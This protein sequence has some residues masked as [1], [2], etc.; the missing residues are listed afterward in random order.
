MTG[1]LDLHALEQ[2]LAGSELSFHLRHFAQAGSTQ[3]LVLRAAAAGTPE[4]LTVFAEEQ[5]LGRGRSGRS[6][7][8]PA[9]SAL[10]FSLLLRPPG[11]PAGWGA[12]SLVAAVAV[13]EGVEGA[14]GPPVEIKW[15]NDCLS[16]GRKLAGIL[17]ES[18]AAPPSS[19]RLVLG[20][21]C[22]VAWGG[23]SLPEEVRAA[24]TAC[25]LEGHPVER[26]VLARELLL[27]LDRR[28]RE[29]RTAGFGA[30]R[31]AWLG[32]A[33]DLGREVLLQL[34]QRTISGRA[35]G[36]SLEG[37]L[38]LATASGEIR[39]GTGEVVVGP[40]PLP[41]SPEDL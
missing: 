41:P 3:D 16:R 15:P 21:G 22:N 26:T 36:V 5:L 28:Y 39:V 4:G 31:E 33:P 7:D 34:Q 14:G 10:L 11:P 2:G 38:I 32:R 29:W 24:G 27:S 20:V 17:S 23:M 30:A 35:L 37:E 9:G 19:P 12:L 18:S 6:W 8:A 25:D 13:A 1:G 40:R